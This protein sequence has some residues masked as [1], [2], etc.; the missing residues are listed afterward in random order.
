M[1]DPSHLIVPRMSNRFNKQKSR[2]ACEMIGEDVY[3]LTIALSY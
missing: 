2:C 1:S 3:D